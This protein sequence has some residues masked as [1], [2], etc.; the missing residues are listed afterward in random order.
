MLKSLSQTEFS[1]YLTKSVSV[2]RTPLPTWLPANALLTLRNLHLEQNVFGE[3]IWT[4]RGLLPL[5]RYFMK[6]SDQFQMS[7]II[8]ELF[9]LLLLLRKN[10]AHWLGVRHE[11]M[12]FRWLDWRTT[13]CAISSRYNCLVCCIGIIYRAYLTQ[14][15]QARKQPV[16]PTTL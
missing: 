8:D 3:P 2:F 16:L 4:R 13:N 1:Q 15:N 12:T 11:L 14:P 10:S 9:H 5:I 6:P 7:W